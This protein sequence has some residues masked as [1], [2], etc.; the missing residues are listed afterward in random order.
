MQHVLTGRS[1]QRPSQR[2][3][4]VAS[5]DQELRLTTPREQGIR[6]G[7]AFGDLFDR[8]VGVLGPAAG[9]AFGE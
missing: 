5:D 8:H 1:E 3:S 4:P 2:S 7:A 9:D 6:R